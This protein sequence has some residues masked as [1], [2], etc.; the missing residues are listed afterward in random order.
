MWLRGP[1]RESIPHESALL[2]H[3]STHSLGF[4]IEERLCVDLPDLYLAGISDSRGQI[5]SPILDKWMQT[6]TLQHFDAGEI[7][8]NTNPRWL[9]NFRTHGLR[10]CV[11]FGAIDGFARRVTLLE[12]Y[13]LP[14][15]CEPPD[16]DLCMPLLELLQS[17]LARVRPGR[18]EPRCDC[19]D[20]MTPAELEVLK[21][22]RLGKTNNE[23]AMIL[24]R[25]RFT[26]KTHVQRMLAKTGLDNRTQ[27]SAFAE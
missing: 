2:L 19:A 4:L 27:L 18:L 20:P 14:A 13:N 26:V 21:W 17:A 16:A 22:V 9:R 15:G 24:G 10:N 5:Q 7:R 11:L 12:L 1:V 3:G 23:I 8:E 25:S 6:R